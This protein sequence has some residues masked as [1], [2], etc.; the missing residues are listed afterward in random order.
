MLKFWLGRPTG[1]IGDAV[2]F[3]RAAVAWAP[4]SGSALTVLPLYV[5]AEL[6]R[7]QRDR[8]QLDALIRRQWTRDHIAADVGRALRTWFD[9]PADQPRAALDLNHL[10]HGLW[11]GGSFEDAGR[12]FDAIG[13]YATT[14]PWSQVADDPAAGEREFTWARGQC[15]STARR[16]GRR[17][18]PG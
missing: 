4:Q 1:S 17:R 15:R 13:P 14:V 2:D 10:A 8:E 5:H 11:A 3:A 7:R 9:Q 12:V 16:P 6:Y 18:H